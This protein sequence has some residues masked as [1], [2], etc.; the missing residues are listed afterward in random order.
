MPS[1]WPRH[2]PSGRSS[3]PPSCGAWP[4]TLE[5]FER[6]YLTP[7]GCADLMTEN[8]LLAR[9]EMLIALARPTWRDPVYGWFNKLEDGNTEYPRLRIGRDYAIPHPVTL[10]ARTVAS[11]RNRLSAAEALRE[12]DRQNLEA[13]ALVKEPYARIVAAYYGHPLDPFQA[14]NFLL[15]Y[16]VHT[17]AGGP[18]GFAAQ[19]MRPIVEFQARI[20]LFRLAVEMRDAPAAAMRR[21]E[22]A[23]AGDPF[24]PWR[25]PY[26]GEL[27]KIDDPA[28]PTRIWSAGPDAVNAP[29]AKGGASARPKGRPID[30]SISIVKNGVR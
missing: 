26:S 12:Y 28:A 22:T 8:Y 21:K 17:N 23:P 3:P 15:R 19:M 1:P 14:K 7:Q 9:Q 18:C 24:N 16:N 2:G 25:D 5:E 6:E 11:I 30:I 29:G 4:P 27:M 13:I 20:H 10:T